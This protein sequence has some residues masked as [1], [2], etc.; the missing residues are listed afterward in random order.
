MRFF[1]RGETLNERLLR[2]ARL[3]DRQTEPAAEAVPP[4]EPLDPVLRFGSSSNR[5][6]GP[7]PC[8]AAS[9]CPPLGRGRD[10][11]GAGAGR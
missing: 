8:W 6:V 1:R 5:S 11:R 10:S 7:T 3:D 4:P 9:A 2:E